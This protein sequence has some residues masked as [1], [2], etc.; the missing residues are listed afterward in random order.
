MRINKKLVYSFIVY[1]VFIDLQ[2]NMYVLYYNI[3]LYIYTY[4]W[5]V[6]NSYL[7]VF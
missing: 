5:D 2:I 1:N 4:S 7:C 6:I 3:Y